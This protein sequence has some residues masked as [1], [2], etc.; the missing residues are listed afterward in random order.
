[1]IVTEGV[2]G[3]AFDNLTVR[4]D[5]RRLADLRS[6]PG[7]LSRA[8]AL[9]VRNRTQVN[10]ELFT[11]APRLRIVAR[12]GVGLDN[13]DLAAADEAGVV[14]SAALGANAVSVA[15]HTLLLALALLR[16]LPKHDRAIREGRWQRT[17]G[18]ELSGRTWGLLGVGAT[19]RAVARLLTGFGVAVIGHDPF[20][21]T[22]DD[23]IRTL[24]IE[25][26]PLARLIAGSDVL[27][28]HLPA[29]D[30]TRG[31]IDADLLAGFRPGSVLINVG[32]GEVMDEAALARAVREGRLGGAAL[33]VRTQEPPVPGPLDGLENVIF[34]PHIAGI[35]EE[36]QRRIA[37][38]L[39]ADVA[40]VLAGGRA[41]AS[42]GRHATSPHR[43]E[44]TR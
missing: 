23:R 20:V 8:V 3:P 35:T 18:R 32:R 10:R 27:S 38:V 21:A 9:V 26:V 33:D 44:V 15:E 12:A 31:L 36:S 37:A 24:G 41:V 40:A 28:V 42:V 2:W 11:V 25:L 16:E 29:T 34:T 14:V 19:G 7:G 6:D 22:D 30:R 4:H 43:R 39:A 17:S 13:I 5:V 1:M